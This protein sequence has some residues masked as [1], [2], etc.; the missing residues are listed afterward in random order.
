M[1]TAIGAYNTCPYPCRSCYA[2]A[3]PEQAMANWEKH[4]AQP[5]AVTVAEILKT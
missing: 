5:M 1:D 4:K 3:S 2:N